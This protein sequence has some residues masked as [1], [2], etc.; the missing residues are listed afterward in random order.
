MRVLLCIAIGLTG[1]LAPPGDDPPPVAPS[2]PPQVWISTAAASGARVFVDEV[3]RGPLTNGC[4]LV[5]APGRHTFEARRQG[6]PLA[7][8]TR[9]LRREERAEITLVGEDPD[10]GALKPLPERPPAEGEPHPTVSLGEYEYEAGAPPLPDDVVQRLE[11]R[12]S[13][14]RACYVQAWARDPRAHGVV[15]VQV[16]VAGD[17]TVIGTRVRQGDPAV[18]RCAEAELER[19]QLPGTGEWGRFEQRFTFAF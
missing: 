6:V 2:A 8:V 3:D 4:G 9:S 10:L 11:P 18:A 14:V 19:L 13:R 17:G 16:D 7:R 12:M 5:V 15:R 1:C